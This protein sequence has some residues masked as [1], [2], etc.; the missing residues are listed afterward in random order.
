VDRHDAVDACRD[1]GRVPRLAGESGF[2]FGGPAPSILFVPLLV[3]VF[4]NGR[5]T[6]KGRCIGS[7]FGPC[8]LLKHTV[9]GHRE[10]L[11]SRARRHRNRGR[12][13]RDGSNPSALVGSFRCDGPGESSR[14]S[15]SWSAACSFH[16]VSPSSGMSCFSG[17][18][19]RRRTE[20]RLDSLTS[21]RPSRPRRPWGYPIAPPGAAPPAVAPPPGDAASAAFS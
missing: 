3:T 10:H 19:E 15:R 18:S 16:P 20:C 21:T 14:L 8:S 9:V 2:L 6:S 12:R 7:C 17:S 4:W 13:L 5:V 1:P 11:D